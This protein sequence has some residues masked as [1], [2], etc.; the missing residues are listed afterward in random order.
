MGR[1][2]GGRGHP[3]G[4]LPSSAVGMGSPYPPPHST[5]DLCGCDDDGTFALVERIRE[6][7]RHS[8]PLGHSAEAKGEAEEGIPQPHG[9]GWGRR[10]PHRRGDSIFVRLWWRR[11][12]ERSR[13][14]FLRHF[15]L[16]RVSGEDG[17]GEAATLSMPI[18]PMGSPRSCPPMVA[19]RRET[20]RPT[21]ATMASIPAA[22]PTPRRP[23]TCTSPPRRW[24]SREGAA[25]RRHFPFHSPVAHSSTSWWASR[26]GWAGRDARHSPRRPQTTT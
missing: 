22:V 9:A 13:D 17:G 5:D 12:G 26:R 1:K 7:D 6:N 10:F 21:R 14:G 23:R 20:E 11:T 15:F 19:W 18:V 3:T 2:G 24:R 4:L 16:E 25:H 8:V